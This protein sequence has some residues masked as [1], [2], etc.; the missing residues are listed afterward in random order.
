MILKTKI[1]F[2]L[3]S[4]IALTNTNAQTYDWTISDG[5]AEWGSGYNATSGGTYTRDG[6]I[7]GPTGQPGTAN[8]GSDN[9]FSE[10]P[11]DG[12]AGIMQATRR[13][14]AFTR[15]DVNT[16]FDLS[17]TNSSAKMNLVYIPQ[18]D[19]G[20]GTGF[21]HLFE[22][23]LTQNE[24]HFGAQATAGSP[25]FGG[26]KPKDESIL[27][28]GYFH[29]PS[30]TNLG[31][32]TYR[33]DLHN[34]S[35]L[36]QNPTDFIWNSSPLMTLDSAVPFD[37]VEGGSG[38]ANSGTIV[39]MELTWTNTGSGN[40]RLDYNL[41]NLDVPNTLAISSVTGSNIVSSG[42]ANFQ[43][44]LT[45]LS[46]LRPGFGYRSNDS[47]NPYSGANYDWNKEYEAFLVP[48]PSSSILTFLGLV[49][50]TLIRRRQ[51]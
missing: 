47:S 20:D 18:L 16:I 11:Y 12:T 43:H 34:E 17:A 44:G 22:V 14:G 36:D 4:G 42:T 26:G 28:S 32:S 1:R 38:A 46:A 49:S 50:I 24:R 40:M 7:V 30:Y 37:G 8:S 33:F 27:V 51:S 41:T 48:E 31:A 10:A 21:T 13:I 15:T 45:D 2:I 25:I 9:G 5:A 3:L 19:I 39:L 35:T 6:N 29:D 23:G